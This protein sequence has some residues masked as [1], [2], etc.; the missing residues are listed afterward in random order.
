M[1]IGGAGFSSIPGFGYDP[2]ALSGGASTSGAHAAAAAPAP[3]AA[4]AAGPTQCEV[5]VDA[6]RRMYGAPWAN[7]L[8]A[9]M[10]PEGPAR[11]AL[12]AA[13]ASPNLKRAI[14][15]TEKI[16]ASGASLPPQ[17]KAAL[18]YGSGA[19]RSSGLNGREGVL[20]PIQ[21][22]NAARAFCGVRP[23]ER[24]AIEGLLAKAGCRGAAP[25]PGADALTEQALIMKA[26]GAR[27]GS[28][29]SADA[30]RRNLALNELKAFAEGIR[31]LPRDT[32]MRQTSLL[33][34]DETRDTARLA[35]L[36]REDRAPGPPSGS[37]GRGGGGAPSD[38]P[39]G[40]SQADNDG[41]YQRYEESCGPTS[42]EV[43]LGE[44]D[45]AY[46]FRRRTGRLDIAPAAADDF[47]T[48]IVKRYDLD[49]GSRVIVKNIA[50]FRAHVDRLGR[51]GRLP[52]DQAREL[53]R[54]VLGDATTPKSSLTD[55]AL[56]TL[57]AG[58]NG[59]PDDAQVG[60]IRAYTPPKP[61]AEWGRIGFSNVE[62]LL[63]EIV[64][65]RTG[66]DYKLTSLYGVASRAL[67]REEAQ[68]RS[69]QFVS[70]NLDRLARNLDDG[71]DVVIGTSWPD[72]FWSASAVDGAK[73][74]RRFLIHDPWSGRTK[75]IPEAKL[76]D[77]SFSR[78]FMGESKTS[79]FVDML[80]MV[81]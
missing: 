33:D 60:A 13:Y 12:F 53:R 50:D 45:P 24:T 10:P 5:I 9:C 37:A 72:H 56:A 54:Y 47:Q 6:V 77:G 58:T 63:D 1:S 70:A 55:R 78:Q 36:S 42:M 27:S 2:S 48:Q 41:L 8:A 49:P 20:S 14:A 35:P 30:G 69:S 17:Y 3:A 68:R 22:G 32:L 57:R 15:T 23:A 80:Y 46:A 38:R 67:P 62:K 11:E 4:P 7:R 66:A 74:D 81:D 73:P 16:A 52:D 44:A 40:G 25:A 26:L 79:T 51:E 75:W 18:I 29:T 59:F 64:G 31:G 71:V 19:T 34:I 76:V 21:A 43:L 61:D 39:V 28:I 65:A